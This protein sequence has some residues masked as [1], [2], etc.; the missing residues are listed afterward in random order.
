MPDRPSGW[1][2]ADEFQTSL[3]AKGGDDISPDQLERWRGEGVLPAVVQTPLK[4]R[5]SVTYYPPG[6]GDQAIAVRDL[7]RRKRK[8][9]YVGWELWW[10]GERFLVDEKHWKPHLQ[11]TAARLDRVENNR[12]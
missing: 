11:V 7:L 12:I 10:R 5:G 6:Y 4:Y 2:S 8:F 1:L 9:E 3:R